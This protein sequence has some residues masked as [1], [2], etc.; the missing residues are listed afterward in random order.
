MTHRLSIVFETLD[1]VFFRDGTPFNRGELQSDAGICF[2]PSPKTLIGAT[3]QYMAKRLGWDGRSRTWDES[4]K[5]EIGDGFGEYDLGGLD[6]AGPILLVGDEI[7]VPLPANFL[8]TKGEASA[9]G[10]SDEHVA[11][12]RLHRLAPSREKYITDLG[13]VRLPDAGPG[14]GGAALLHPDWWLSLTEF[15]A[16]LNG[17]RPNPDVLRHSTTLWQKE[18]R[19]GIQR[20]E[21]RTTPT[22]GLYC[23]HHIRLDKIGGKPVRLMMRCGYSGDRVNELLGNDSLQTIGGESRSGWIDVVRSES[24]QM[25]EL[26]MPELVSDAD[27]QIQYAVYVITP[28]KP[29]APPSPGEPFEGLPGIV[30]TAC[31]PKPVF[32]GGW[33]SVDHRPSSLEPYLAT[34]SVIFMECQPDDLTAVAGIHNSHVGRWTSWGFGLVSTLR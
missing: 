22:N 15:S 33:N 5:N 4:C 29:E 19:V 25:D 23:P 34:G 3:R 30:V 24:K 14:V 10:S 11:I 12:K 26:K 2:P 1:T 21:S 20:D 27:G 8:G 13:Q 6:F 17:G 32:F 7:H 18:S 31:L 16:I 28:L 9:V